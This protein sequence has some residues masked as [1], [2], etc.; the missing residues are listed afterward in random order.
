[1]KWEATGAPRSEFQN[2]NVLSF[3]QDDP[4]SEGRGKDRSSGT[5]TIQQS[6]HW[7]SGYTGRNPT[8]HPQATQIRNTREKVAP[9]ILTRKEF[10]RSRKIA[11]EAG[12]EE[13]QE[14]DL[15]EKASI[16]NRSSN[17][18]MPSLRSSK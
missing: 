12:S 13:E 6:K 14:Q 7:A 17:N 2:N 16:L 5:S 10:S 8:Q 15:A 4:P 1:M 18:R 9:R 11:G 3:T